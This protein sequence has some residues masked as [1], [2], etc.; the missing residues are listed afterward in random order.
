ME[1]SRG[2]GEHKARIV[3]ARAS[4]YIAGTLEGGDGMVTASKTA[5][6]VEECP[7]GRIITTMNEDHM[8]GNK[9]NKKIKDRKESVLSTVVQSPTSFTSSVS[10]QYDLGCRPCTNLLRSQASYFAAPH[11][12]HNFWKIFM[13]LHMLSQVIMSAEFLTA[14]RIW[15]FMRYRE[16][17]VS[18]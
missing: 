15:A 3:E 1:R 18:T 12:F 7:K 14:P 6:N 9:T 5:R 11:A 10:D 17:L 16:D 13:N 4:G 2:P 8:L